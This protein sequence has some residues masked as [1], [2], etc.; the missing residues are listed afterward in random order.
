[1]R[2]W[3][4]ASCGC[5]VEFTWV[6]TTEGPAAHIIAE[7]GTS[8]GL[9]SCVCP[10]PLTFTLSPPSLTTTTYARSSPAMSSITQRIQNLAAFTPK[11]RALAQN[12]DDIVIVTA[13]RSAITKVRVLS[14]S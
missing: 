8:V 10:G 1:M 13:V 9:K 14:Y 4:G 11:A 6:G 2:G 3:T 12:D 5:G 7:R